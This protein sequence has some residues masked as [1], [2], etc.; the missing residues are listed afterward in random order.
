M[1]ILEVPVSHLPSEVPARAARAGL[2]R[3]AVLVATTAALAA[4]GGAGA[5]APASTSAHSSTTGAGTSGTFRGGPPGVSGQIAEIDGSTLQVQDPTSGQTAVVVTATTTYTQ[6]EAGSLA[7]V[8]VGSCIVA[9]SPAASSPT[10]TATAVPSAVPTAVPSA[11]PTA[12]PTGPRAITAGTVL[13]TPA[14]NGSCTRGFGASGA[15]G[16]TARPSGLPTN[17]PSGVP[18]G[19]RNVGRF[20]DV[21]T[22]VVTAVT[23]SVISVQ[24]E[25]R[26]SGSTPTTVVDTVTVTASTTYQR[27]A[28]ATRSALAVGKCVNASGTQGSDGT[29]TAAR[30][31]ISAPSSTGCTTGFRRFG[32]GGTPTGTNG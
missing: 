13:I 26:G 25:Q 1:T 18:S 29:L 19:A 4:C 17:R 20:G 30:V 15:G 2:I 11:M 12:V 3:G 10:A 16:G 8:R 27:T 22:G 28:A 14:V 5:H 21:V 23:G 24:A 7:D 9:T 6:T 31:A 32:A